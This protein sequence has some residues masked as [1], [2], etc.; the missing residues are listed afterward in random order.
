L[1]K[2]L[3]AHNSM[4]R[5]FSKRAKVAVGSIILV[6]SFIFIIP[7]YAKDNSSKKVI[8]IGIYKATILHGLEFA[9]KYKTPKE[10]VVQIEETPL[11][12]KSDS[13]L[14]VC[15][16]SYN[17]EEETFSIKAKM[18][19]V[20]KS[21]FPINVDVL[22]SSTNSL[23]IKPDKIGELEL[24]EEKSKY[25]KLNSQ[26]EVHLFFKEELNIDNGSAKVSIPAGS[27]FN[28]LTLH[29]LFVF[30][31][32]KKNLSVSAESPLLIKTERGEY[33]TCTA[34]LADTQR[35]EVRT[36]YYAGVNKAYKI[37]GYL[38]DSSDKIIG[39]KP[40][41]SIIKEG[42]FSAEIKPNKSVLLVVTEPVMLD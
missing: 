42:V 19:V 1:Q 20:D 4:V 40:A 37:K 36:E 39:I 2:L 26:K 28:A 15:N 22:D 8:P 14:F 30:A 35:V 33:I 31:D 7:S 27:K 24:N 11:L 38:V 41:V 34:R 10:P 29:G 5:F 16:A 32:K 18:L 21:E 17:K 9:F 25:A 12:I 23:E 13:K 3:S 6:L